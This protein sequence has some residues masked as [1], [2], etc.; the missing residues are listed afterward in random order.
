MSVELT[1]YI[2]RGVH[3]SK[4]LDHPAGSRFA[5]L[6]G[7]MKINLSSAWI[8]V[9]LY[10]KFAAYNKSHVHPAHQQAG[11]L[12]DC[13]VYTYTPVGGPVPDTGDSYID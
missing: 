9:P 3:G 2:R 11:D 7:C 10:F 12:S 5:D 4:I 8:G 6:N 13:V 1:G